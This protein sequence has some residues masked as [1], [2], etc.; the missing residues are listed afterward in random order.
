MDEKHYH[1][2]IMREGT[3]GIPLEIDLKGETELIPEVGDADD[4]ISCDQSD[5]VDM[6]WSVQGANAILQLRILWKNGKWNKFWNDR[7]NL[8]KIA[9]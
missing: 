8:S 7:N 1:S 6:K 9:A 4:G 2:Q 3:D 5:W